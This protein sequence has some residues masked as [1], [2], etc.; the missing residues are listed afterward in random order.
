MITGSRSLNPNNEQANV[1]EPISGAH[2]ELIPDFTDGGSTPFLTFSDAANLVDKERAS[3]GQRST[4][5]QL[6]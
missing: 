6:H 4:I 3:Y 2:A 1:S 5:T